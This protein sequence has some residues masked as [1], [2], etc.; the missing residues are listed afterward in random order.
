[1]DIRRAHDAPPIYVRSFGSKEPVSSFIGDDYDSRDLTDGYRGRNTSDG[2]Q[3]ENRAG[4]CGGPAAMRS[5]AS[6][7]HWLGGHEAEAVS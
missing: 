4:S 5:I 2:R 7:D 6:G 1:M 3:R